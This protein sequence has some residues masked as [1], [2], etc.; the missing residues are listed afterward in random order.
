MDYRIKILLIFP[1]ILIIIF[2]VLANS[3]R[4]KG[5]PSEIERRIL[6]FSPSDIKVRQRQMPYTITSALKSPID[7]SSADSTQVGFPPV[8]LDALAPQP[9]A[10]GTD[11]KEELSLI[12]I[13]SR[14]RLAIL[15]GVVVREGDSF[16]GIKVSK[17]EPDRVLLADKTI[18]WVSIDKK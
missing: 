8:A 7:F 5:Q 13:G 15:N 4:I 2:V 12:V 14:N 3:I 10:S 6:E 11:S 17:I 1:L 18:K 16:N 9:G